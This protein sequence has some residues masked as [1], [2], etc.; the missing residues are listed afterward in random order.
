[1]QKED[2]YHQGFMCYGIPLG[3]EEFVRQKL[4]QKSKEIMDDAVRMVDVLSGDRQALWEILHLSNMAGKLDEH[5]WTTLE[6]AMG[7]TVPRGENGSTVTCRVAQLQGQSYQEWVM[8]LSIR[9]HG[10][11]FR[12]LAETCGPAYLGAL[13]QPSPTWPPGTS[14][15]LSGSWSGGVLGGGC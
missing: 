6:A 7:F 13:G 15:A 14:S 8:R 9:L 3:S 11:G 1:M 12:S 2:E 4:Q 10:W 5:L